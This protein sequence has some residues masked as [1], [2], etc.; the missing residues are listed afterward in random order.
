MNLIDAFCE[1]YAWRDLHVEE[2]DQ[3]AD[4][5]EYL[6]SARKLRNAYKKEPRHRKDA[7][8]LF[9]GTLMRW[10]TEVGNG[11]TVSHRAMNPSVTIVRVSPA[12]ELAVFAQCKRLLREAENI[13][14]ER[15]GLPRIGEGWVS[16]TELFILLRDAFDGTKVAQHTRPDWLSPQHLD[17][18]FPEH[19]IGVEYQ[20]AQHI[21][22][23]DYFGGEKAFKQ[24]QRR[25][26]RKR[27][28]CKKHKCRL[29][30]V[31]QGYDIDEVV[32]QVATAI[33]EAY[34]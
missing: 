27:R 33:M 2:L 15:V 19:L 1:Q 6:V 3:I 32:A 11:V 18:F 26:A 20:G 12:I 8:Y 16:E 7:L 31:F 23:V 22:P 9:S 17:V 30:E 24:Q 4:D 10:V 34:Q 28:L 25:D 21:K 5:C 29:I 13:V 14:R